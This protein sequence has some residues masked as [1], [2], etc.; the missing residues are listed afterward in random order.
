MPASRQEL[1]NTLNRETAKSEKT[2][3]Q[4]ENDDIP[5]LANLLFET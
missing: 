2:S 4:K 3:Q 1:K 5:V